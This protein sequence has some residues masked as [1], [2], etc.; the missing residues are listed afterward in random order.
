MKKGMR[1][2]LEVAFLVRLF[3]GVLTRGHALFPLLTRQW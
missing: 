3:L 2:E 1:L